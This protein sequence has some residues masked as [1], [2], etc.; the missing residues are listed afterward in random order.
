MEAKATLL[1]LGPEDLRLMSRFSSS[2]GLEL[3]S[4]F[5]ASGEPMLP[6]S[7]PLAQEE[8]R[9]LAYETVRSAYEIALEEVAHSLNEVHKTSLNLKSWR[10]ALGGWL[11]TAVSVFYDRYRII[12]VASKLTRGNLTVAGPT[13]KPHPF[14]NSRAFVRAAAGSESWNRNLLISAGDWILGTRFLP[15]QLEFPTTTEVS[16]AFTLTEAHSRLREETLKAMID[17]ASR[18]RW[19]MVP[20]QRHTLVFDKS[21]FSPNQELRLRRKLSRDVRVR[22]FHAPSNWLMPHSPSMRKNF[23][24]HLR[25]ASTSGEDSNFLQFFRESLPSMIPISYLESFERIRLTSSKLNPKPEAIF[26]AQSHWFDD[27]FKI[28]AASAHESGTELVVGEHG[29]SFPAKQYLFD[30]EQAL[31]DRFISGWPPRSAKEVQ[32]PISNFVGRKPLKEARRQKQLLIVGYPVEKWSLRPSSQP[33]SFRGLSTLQ[34][35][36]TLSLDL[37]P[38]IRRQTVY[39]AASQPS[40]WERE[41]FYL[42]ELN[43]LGVRTDRRKL[44]KSLKSAKLVVCLYPQTTFS[45]AFTANR[46][47]ILVFDETVSGIDSNAREVISQLKDAQILFTDAHSASQFVSQ[48]WD[49]PKEWWES[50]RVRRA[51]TT[52]ARYA[53]LEEKDPLRAWAQFFIQLI[54]SLRAP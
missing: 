46:P 31:S 38:G 11:P 19:P 2:I 24:A 48:V 8:E 51:R 29:G 14:E 47:T 32:L 45:D 3:H 43:D 41:H 13:I 1:V 12:E 23:E 34:M 42:R 37:E 40:N 5:S 50:S 22:S 28:W 17:F 33:Q 10:I 15:L 52:F 27:P 21:C 53:L 7:Y 36:L 54:P 35:A 44:G 6:M 25:G 4:E 26:T 9:E 39:K 20:R 49:D 18:S 16:Q 30:F